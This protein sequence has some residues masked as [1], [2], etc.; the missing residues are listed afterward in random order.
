MRRS[1]PLA[2]VLALTAVLVAGCSDDA[3][4][5]EPSQ[6][7]SATETSTADAADTATLEAVT[8]T[9][10]LGAT[11]TV[12]FTMPLSLG[13][14]VARMETEGT[15]EPIAADAL[16]EVSY[17]IFSGDD[18]SLVVSTWDEDA[19]EVVPLSALD[20]GFAPLVEVL[21]GAPIGSRLVVGIPGSEATDEAE[22]VPASLMVL[23]AT[24]VV[25]ARAEGDPVAPVDGLPAVTLAEDGAPSIEV[26]ADFTEPT[27]LVAEPLITG[28]GDVVESGDV[29]TVQYTGWLTDGTEF[30]SSWGGAQPFQTQ[31]G[32][33][34]VV[35]G[36]DQGLVG[37]T[38]GSQVLLVIP[39]DL[40]YGDEGSGETIPGG[41]TLVFVVDI[42]HAG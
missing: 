36:W 23:E 26:P 27:E 25:P 32:V 9:G 41:A 5:P 15:G 17:A 13:T 12:E 7:E 19:S 38:V 8:V 29:I 6:T 2:L 21:T 4:A 14:T 34:A 3:T 35:D 28:A 20:S 37:Q 18:A 16:L 40:G 1:A 42:L 30:D 10:D 39:S 11:P 31:I 22:A 24:R 33:G